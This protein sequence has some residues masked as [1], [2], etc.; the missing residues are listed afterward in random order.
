MAIKVIDVSYAQQKVDFSKIKDA[1]ISAVIIRTGYYGKTDTMFHSHM[2]GAI[3]AGLD[4]GVYTYI[5][6]ENVEQAV[7]EAKQTISRLEQYKGYVNYPVF[8]D[9]EH[10][11]Y[12]NNS[13]YTRADRTDIIEAF[14][15]TV[16]ENGYYPGV[17]INPSWLNEWVEMDA[18]KG[19]Y[20]IWLAAWT[21]NPDI[22]TRYDYG[23]KMWQ[24]GTAEV[25]GISG[26]VDSNLCYVDY[27]TIISRAG[28]NYLS[29]KCV[30]MARKEI[31]SSQKDET[32]R[33]LKDM[34]F[35]VCTDCV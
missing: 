14:C 29:E 21:D 25:D 12:Y 32:I 4:I 27:P 10:N 33:Q 16:S 17:Y 5:M 23:Q 30:I 31:S 34:G 7:T 19:K 24:W 2:N 26:R 28:K 35:S 15:N 8:C 9:M 18:I 1:G 13:L 20:D 11:K 6:A 3:A 22:Q